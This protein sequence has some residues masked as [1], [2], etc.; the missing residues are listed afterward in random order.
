MKKKKC[1][2]EAMSFFLKINYKPSES[3]QKFIPVNLISKLFDFVSLS[4]FSIGLFRKCGYWTIKN[5]RMLRI[6]KNL[7]ALIQ[8]NYSQF[9][10]ITKLRFENTCL[11]KS[12]LSIFKSLEPVIFF[13][14]SLM[15]NKIK[16]KISR[17]NFFK[18]N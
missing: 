7:L 12:F 3:Y 2:I 1:Q 8:F 15:K 13:C 11:N 9:I 5:R 18:E 4:F 14:F 17:S 16:M 10:Y 6:K